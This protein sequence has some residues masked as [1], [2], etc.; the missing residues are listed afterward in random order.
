MAGEESCM[1]QGKLVPKIVISTVGANSGADGCC[2]R[3][4]PMRP[5]AVS[6]KYLRLLAE[7]CTAIVERFQFSR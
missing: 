1:R 2:D 6:C 7:E 5:P 3:F 4:V